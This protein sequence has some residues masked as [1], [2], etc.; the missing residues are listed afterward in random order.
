MNN[1]DS[2]PLLV[3]PHDSFPKPTLLRHWMVPILINVVVAVL[4]EKMTSD[5][6][7]EARVF[8]V[9]LVVYSMVGSCYYYD[10]YDC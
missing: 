3:N 10:D 2:V 4:L 8:L 9:L 5:E 1:Q 7:S 6:G